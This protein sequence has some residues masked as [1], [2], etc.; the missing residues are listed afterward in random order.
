MMLGSSVLWSVLDNRLETISGELEPW[1]ILLQLNFLPTSPKKNIKNDFHS[2]Y[3][4][5]VLVYIAFNK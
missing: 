2:N 3:I 1:P 5:N 4:I